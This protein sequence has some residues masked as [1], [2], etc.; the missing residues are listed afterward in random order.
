MGDF[1]IVGLALICN[2]FSSKGLGKASIIVGFILPLYNVLTIVALI[3]PL[4]DHKR[5]TLKETLI[6]IMRNPL[7]LA[8]IISLPFSYFEISIGDTVRRSGNHVSSL[9]LPLALIGIGGSLDFKELR[10]AS[11]TA[12]SFTML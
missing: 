12:L 10:K 6:E 7:T 9:A 8:V 1:A 4:R 5:L 2:M 11:K 3:V